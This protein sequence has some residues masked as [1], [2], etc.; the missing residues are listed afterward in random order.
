[1][2]KTQTEI[3][4]DDRDQ[5][6][7][8]A[9]AENEDDIQAAVEDFERLLIAPSDWTVST[10]YDLIGK[11][12]QLD[13]AY[14]RRNVWQA[15]AKSQF[16]ESL[17]L[18]IPIPQILLASKAGQKNSF[19]VLDGKQRLSTIREFLD[20]F[21][22]DG[23]VFK[24]KGLRILTALENKTWADL[25]SY[26]DWS[27]RLRNEPIRTTVLRGWENESV[28]YEIFYRLNSGSVKLSPM[29]LRMSLLPGDFLK[30][31]ISWTEAI[32]PIHHLLRKRQPDARMSD[33]ELAIRYLSFRDQQTQYVGDLKKFLDDFCRLKN[34]AFSADPAQ[35]T[36]YYN[37]L[38]ELNEA[39]NCGLMEFGDSHFCRKYSNDEYETRFNRAVFDVLV[40]ALSHQDVRVW[41]ENNPGAMKNLY[42][43]VC[44]KNLNFVKS[45]ESTTK[46]PDAVRTR[47]GT[48]YSLVSNESGVKLSIPDVK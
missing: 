15:K 39:I 41:V 42:E 32:G 38:S 1:M 28:L 48:W 7:D 23:K 43:S 47:F 16:I 24:L 10:I 27:D 6:E 34:M 2:I 33:V 17:F 30:F 14:Q 5:F 26:D 4:W 20:G 21:Y 8:E 18:G 29:E 19:L 31:I 3:S 11:Q 46:S 12:L 37:L 36:V 40:G 45:V 22:S 13:P 25:Q 44:S 35:K 9:T